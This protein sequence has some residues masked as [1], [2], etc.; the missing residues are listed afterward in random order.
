MKLA[1][2]INGTALTDSRDRDRTRGGGIAGLI[3]EVW[4][5]AGCTRIGVGTQS[6]CRQMGSG[7][8]RT[9]RVGAGRP[10]GSPS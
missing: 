5:V 2:A 9:E 4:Q 6:N 7:A 10:R 8:T 1:E 3:L